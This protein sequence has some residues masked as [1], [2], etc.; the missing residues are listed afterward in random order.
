MYLPSH[1]QAQETRQRPWLAR[2]ERDHPS[3][4]ARLLA[5]AIPSVRAAC[6]EAGLI[7]LPSRLDALKREWARASVAE[8]E[9][10]LAWLKGVGSSSGLSRSLPASL[11]GSD[12]HLHPGVVE[13]IGAILAKSSPG[14]SQH[15]RII[16]AM[17]YARSSTKLSNAL[18]RRGKPTEEFLQRLRNWLY[19]AEGGGSP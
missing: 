1:A 17:G 14:R 11:V 6:A 19:S 12:G 10:F 15:G 18:M 8:R 4:H 16:S 3:I 7:R 2:L 13:R 5:G 9:T